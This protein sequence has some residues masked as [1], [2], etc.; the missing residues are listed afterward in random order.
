MASRWRAFSRLLAKLALVLAL[1]GCTLRFG[2]LEERDGDASGDPSVPPAPGQPPGDEPVRDAARLARE[3][4]VERYVAE[5]IYQGAPVV[6][7]VELPSGD[8]IDGLDRSWLPALPYDAP[9]LPWR[10]EELGLPG[11]ELARLGAERIPE[12]GEL[13]A[14][15]V[16]V[17]GPT[18]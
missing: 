8:V 6:G 7:T 17:Q 18:F 11:V 15:A 1:G 5:V 12:L 9:P 2:P 4:E 10:A 13:V 3:Q 16:P 14:A